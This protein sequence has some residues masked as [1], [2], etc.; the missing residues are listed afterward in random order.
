MTHHQLTHWQKQQRL[1]R[2]VLITGI[3]LIVA[4]IAIIGT[5]LYF[6]KIKPA[7][8]LSEKLQQVVLKIDNTTYDLDYLTD[9]MSFMMKT[10]QSFGL[11]PNLQYLSTY[12][13]AAVQ[14]TEGNFLVVEAA[15]KLKIPD[16]VST[17]VAANIKLP[18]TV[19]DDEVM[20]YI[21]DNE[22][23]DK[24]FTKDTVLR[25]LLIEKI[26]ADYFSPQIPVT[27]EHRAVWAMLLESQ[28]QAN[29]VQDRITKGESFPDIAAELSLDKTTKE[30][31]G[32]L[33][34]L[35]KGIL[36]STLSN[37]NASNVSILENK[38]FSADIVK[39][40]LTTAD[41]PTLS[42]N[43]GYWLIKVTEITEADNQTHAYAMLLG[44]LQQAEDIKA[45]LAA[46]GEGNDW[47]TLAKA[48][49]QW[50]NASENGGDLGNITKGTLGNVVDTAIFDAD[51]K[52]IIAI[53]TVTGPLA[54]TTQTTNGAVWLIQVNG[55]E[56]QTT[57]DANRT[58]L[59]GDLFN[60]WFTQYS[61]DNV[62]RFVDEFNDELQQFAFNE[63]LKR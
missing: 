10:Y 24:Q 29:Q 44:N 18:V 56:E 43:I 35:P 17:E 26:Q 3:V 37:T 38:I 25:Q 48:N 62:S 54:D 36:A 42:K 16:T 7:Q 55:I 15:S 40:E 14:S 50:D 20:K 33:G 39:N 47:A 2:I 61:Q 49:S 28:A 23:S 58:T 27:T 31:K 21:K 45:K 41:D 57:S 32:D 53:D 12:S 5:G 11:D 46:G 30:K 6:S 63:A 52:P 1:Q 4:I 19:S 51:G 9:A 59:I 22:L 13:N 34:W 8:A 60:D